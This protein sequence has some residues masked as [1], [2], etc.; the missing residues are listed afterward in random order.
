MPFDD[1]YDM[2][3]EAP[4]SSLSGVSS[5]GNAKNFVLGL[6][7][8]KHPVISL[9][10]TKTLPRTNHTAAMEIIRDM[11]DQTFIDLNTRALFVDM[12]FYNLRGLCLQECDCARYHHL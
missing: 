11:K 9:D 2:D 5:A 6:L 3:T 7:K 8:Y 12:S 10:D 1:R 4:H